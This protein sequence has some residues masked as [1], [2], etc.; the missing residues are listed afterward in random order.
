MCLTELRC[1]WFGNQLIPPSRSKWEGTRDWPRAVKG[2]QWKARDSWANKM[3]EGE[4][5]VFEGSVNFAEVCEVTVGG[6]F[7]SGGCLSSA[8][9]LYLA[10]QNLRGCRSLVGSNWVEIEPGVV[11]RQD[12]CQGKGS[13]FEGTVTTAGFFGGPDPN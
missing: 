6:V 7:V 3:G 13:L 10:I 9:V 12:C 11:G 1:C 8:F 5:S 4:K 2:G